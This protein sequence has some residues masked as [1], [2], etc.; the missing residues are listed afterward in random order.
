ML[1]LFAGNVQFEYLKNC[2]IKCAKIST[3]KVGPNF[4]VHVPLGTVKLTD[5]I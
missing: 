3:T 5:S 2:K 4:G 1:F